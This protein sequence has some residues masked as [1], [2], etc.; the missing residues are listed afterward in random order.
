MNARRR[1][2]TP[3]HIFDNCQICLGVER[4][5]AL[6]EHR[7]AE[8]HHSLHRM[9]EGTERHGGSPQL[10]DAR[11]L[12]LLARRL[13]QHVG[14]FSELEHFFGMAPSSITAV[15]SALRSTSMGA[16]HP[17]DIIASHRWRSAFFA[18]A[19]RLGLASGRQMNRQLHGCSAAG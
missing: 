11:R 7:L 1:V 16:M 2:R 14:L 10:T 17:T 6:D 15:T 8:A 3:N 4:R 5:Q 9:S 13:N 18:G 12:N 19:L